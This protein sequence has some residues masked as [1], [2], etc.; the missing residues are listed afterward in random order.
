[1]AIT[2]LTNE[3]GQGFDDRLKAL[4]QGSADS[5]E[6]AYVL[7]VGGD[8][9]GGVKN[10]GNVII[11][12]DGTM[13]APEGGGA[14]L[15]EE[16]ETI[17]L[18]LLRNAHYDINPDPLIT[19]LEEIWGSSGGSG[20]ESGTEVLNDIFYAKA[21]PEIVDGAWEFANTSDTV[22]SSLGYIVMRPGE[23]LGG[24]LTIA[25]N[26]EE[27]DGFQFSIRTMDAIGNAAHT[28]TGNPSAGGINWVAAGEG[29]TTG[30]IPGSPTEIA[31]PAA[32]KPYVIFRM[33]GSTGTI[34]DGLTTTSSK[35]EAFLNWATANLRCT[36]TEN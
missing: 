7:P 11:N 16:E 14:G 4:E 3:D 18:T 9:L 17:I 20:E 12:E 23:I 2:F 5:G 24:K 10:G 19:R 34:Y 35:T 8:E 30:T 28:S 36:I 29:A 32:E 26:T 6:N 1:M 25:Y 33:N 22:S 15:S 31:I 21:W 27:C 13:T